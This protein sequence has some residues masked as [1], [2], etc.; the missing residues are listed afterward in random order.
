MRLSYL[1][2]ELEIQT[3]INVTFQVLISTLSTLQTKHLAIVKVPFDMGSS[4]C[5]AMLCCEFNSQYTIC[6]MADGLEFKL[7]V[8]QHGMIRKDRL[9]SIAKQIP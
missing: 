2:N 8:Q 4:H 9:C 7:V 3:I 1:K 6:F 5:G